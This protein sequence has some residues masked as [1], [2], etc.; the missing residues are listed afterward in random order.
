[1][2]VPFVRLVCLIAIHA[3]ASPSR[4]AGM[5]SPMSWSPDSRWLAYTASYDPAAETTRP[6]WL[7]GS[8]AGNPE[9]TAA[10]AS[11]RKDLAGSAGFR[12]WAGDQNGRS[13]VLIEESRWP[14]SAPAWSPLGRSLAFSRFVPESASPAGNSQPGRLELVIQRSLDEKKVIWTSPEFVL[15]EATRAA[16]PDHR[17]AWSPDGA[18]LAIPRPGRVPSVDIIRSDSGKRVHILDH[19]ILPA[20]SPNGTMCAYI[21]RGIGSNSLEVVSR[22]GQAFGEPRELRSTGPVTAAP[23]WNTDGQ[24]ILVVSEITTSP[25]RDFVL[26]RCALDSSEPAQILNLVPDPVKRVAKLRGIAIDFDKEAEVCF[27]AADLENRDSE[28][29]W[30]MLRDPRLHRR[31]HP[32]DPSLRIGAVSV[33]PDGHCAAVRFGDPDALSHPALYGAEAE[34]TRLLVPDEIARREWLKML[35]TTAARLLRA[36]LPPVVASGST[37]ERLTVLPLPHELAGLGSLGPRLARIAEFGEAL[38]PARSKLHQSNS[39]DTEA[40]LLFSYLRGDIRGAAAD[41]DALDQETTDSDQR[42]SILSMRALI[43]WAQGDPDQASQIIAYLVSTT[44][45]ATENVEDTPLGPAVGKFVSPAQAWAA[46]LSVH[47]AAAAQS[48][49]AVAPATPDV[50]LFDPLGGAGQRRLLEPPP[51]PA[52][53]PGGAA[54]PFAPLAP[55][56]APDLDPAPRP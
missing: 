54:G 21:R 25:I 6:G 7:L 14:L 28:L 11:T 4:A 49:G 39:T 40:R 56:P 15:D 34:Q 37:F 45:T 43:R 13:T 16:L 1:M 3:L 44:G 31:S 8:L 27:H 42:L 36:G 24:S 32:V 52:F 50:D 18:Y 12:I 20:W 5:S 38:L 23:F 51:F 29:V 30:T 53:E 26:I 17:A 2:K 33:S 41:L 19:A 55:L 48:Q 46:F 10:G 47:A 9:S 22:R 35:S